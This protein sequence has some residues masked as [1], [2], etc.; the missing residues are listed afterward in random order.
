M[1]NMYM[2][3]NFFLLHSEGRNMVNLVYIVNKGF[4]VCGSGNGVSKCAVLGV[5]GGSINSK[6]GGRVALLLASHLNHGCAVLSLIV[7]YH[8]ISRDSMNLRVV[9]ST[10]TLFI[11]LDINSRRLE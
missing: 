5:K 8:R 3:S 9:R 6:H 7:L 11:R 4:Y 1:C 2:A 10:R